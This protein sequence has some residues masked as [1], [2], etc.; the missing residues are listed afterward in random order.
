MS[1]GP[2]APVF[3]FGD[4]ELDQGAYELRR[5]GARVPLAGQ[6]FDLLLLLVSR[7]GELVPRTDIARCLWPDTVFVDVDAGIHTAVLKIRR[8]LATKSGAEPYVES[9]PGRGYRFT[10][11]VSRDA[12]PSPPPARRHNLPADL[13]PFIGRR[14]ELEELPRLL[15]GSRL[16][17]IV[18]TGG[19]GKTRVAIRLAGDLAGQFPDGVWLADFGAVASPDFVAQTVAEAVNVHGTQ[20]QSALET[21]LDF[22]RNR[23]A[24]LVLDTC[25]HVIAPCASLVETLLRGAPDLRV[26]ATSR[27]ALAVA[28]EVVYRLPSLSLPDEDAPFAVVVGSEAGSLFVE[29]ATKVDPAFV[30]AA[31]DAGSIARIC[32]CLD[33]I[34][35]GI[36]LAAARVSML[37]LEQIEARLEDRFRLLG[38][39]TRTAV[40][41][42]R[43]LEATVE[44]SY[45]LLS[46]DERVLLQRLS[47]FPASWTLEAA[48]AICCQ[49]PLVETQLLNLLSRLVD[50]SVVVIDRHAS[51]AYR[52]RLLD[53]VRDYARGRVETQTA[54]DD[55]GRRHFDAF[56]DRFR[57]SQQVMR[58]VGQLLR[59]KEL[60]TEQDNVRAALEWGFS[61]S[62]RGDAAVEL[63]GALFWYWTKCGLFEEGKRWLG[64][65]VA[66]GAAPA[67]H[68]RALIGLAHM[69]HFQGDQPAVIVMGSQATRL[70]GDCDDP[71]AFSVGWFLQAL[72]A[73]ELG[74]LD[75]ALS[76]AGAALEAAEANGQTIERGGPLM[77]LANV[78]LAR[79]DHD[80]ALRL[81]D[82]SIDVHR[83]C[84]D[85][86]GLSILLTTAAGLRV[87]RNDFESARIQATEA[88]ALGRALDDPRGI[89]WSLEVFAG[90]F[91]AA[92]RFADAARTWGLSN[93]LVSGSG[94]TLTTTIGWIR[95]RH[96]ERVKR[97]LGA[98]MFDAAMREGG[99]M[100]LDAVIAGNCD[101]SSDT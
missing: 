21:L 70:G 82:E 55:L 75:Q 34:P 94:G 77:V 78:A 79:G 48:E 50:K 67:L 73:F 60:R 36:E 100:T 63:A 80:E 23:A 33:G 49:P 51:D 24:L 95:D 83:R 86:W 44:W 42:H 40:P 92:G 25:E 17:S 91:A 99:R 6:P 88:L 41:R 59:L 45:Q 14:K 20:G 27:E 11:P 29:R 12:L 7:A 1:A 5:G 97:E 31:A 56:Y 19:V 81:F 38:R 47:V 57:D 13:T 93:T 28:G 37:T 43:T 46:E 61:S 65:A 30:P 89:A 22:F 18:G 84:G 52:Y 71:W 53:T 64:R 74:D 66:A 85:A 101:H 72:A 39:G 4:F 26:V 16:V 54:A 2:P 10:A 9:V 98:P 69:H 96:I 32:R 58:G 35:L 3:R 90:L 76:A 68:A 62:A 15:A 8:A 87:A